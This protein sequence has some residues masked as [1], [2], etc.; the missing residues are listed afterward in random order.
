MELH[1]KREIRRK[2]TA[3]DFT[4]PLLVNEMLDKLPSEV[5]IDPSKTFIDPAA[6]NGNFLVE[7][8][9]RKLSN[10]HPPLIALSTIF[11]VELMEDNTI[12]MKERLLALIPLELHEEAKIILDKNI[13]CSDAF[14]WDFENWRPK[15]KKSKPLF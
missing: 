8:L 3:E 12:E 13:I 6:G 1:S 7:V 10:S 14:R 15:E 11:A 5:F 4:P 9:S 2:I